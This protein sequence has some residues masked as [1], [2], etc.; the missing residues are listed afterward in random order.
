MEK[1]NKHSIEQKATI[2]SNYFHSILGGTALHGEGLSTDT[3]QLTDMFAIKTTRAEGF[4]RIGSVAFEWG[5]SSSPTIS[6]LAE[7]Q[8]GP[9]TLSLG[10]DNADRLISIDPADINKCSEIYRAND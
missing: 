9:L 10:P 1:I 5:S 7:T 3:F 2:V 4:F 6:I 8:E